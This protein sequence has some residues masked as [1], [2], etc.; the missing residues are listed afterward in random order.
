ME[1]EA[2]WRDF[3]TYFETDFLEVTTSNT[4][5]KSELA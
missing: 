1:G 3:R 5:K 2:G 4:L